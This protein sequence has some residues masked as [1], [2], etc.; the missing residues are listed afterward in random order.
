MRAVDRESNVIPNTFKNLL[1]TSV[2]ESEVVTRDVSSGKVDTV[3]Q[4]AQSRPPG[5]AVKSPLVERRVDMTMALLRT[6]SFTTEAM[7]SEQLGLRFEPY[8]LSQVAYL[9]HPEERRVFDDV[10]NP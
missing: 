6:A 9:S 1:D 7:S 3:K 2:L 8:R 4:G 5:V 10:Y